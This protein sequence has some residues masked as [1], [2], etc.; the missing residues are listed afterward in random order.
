MHGTCSRRLVHREVFHE[1]YNILGLPI[2]MTGRRLEVSFDER[3][4]GS[5]SSF[6]VMVD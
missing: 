2:S 6:A 4:R 1:V 5:L 3:N